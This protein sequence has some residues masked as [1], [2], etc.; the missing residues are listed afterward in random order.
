MTGAGERTYARCCS[1]RSARSADV[2]DEIAEALRGLPEPGRV[3]VIGCGGKLPVDMPA[4][5]VADFD[6]SK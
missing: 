2:A 6:K 1:G 5:I 3:A 4:A